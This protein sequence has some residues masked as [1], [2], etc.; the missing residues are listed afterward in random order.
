MVSAVSMTMSNLGKAWGYTKR[1]GEVI[2]ELI[3][4]SAS[5]TVGEALRTTKGSLFTKAQK[6]WQALEKAGSGN[7]FQNF[8]RN[9]KSFYPCIRANVL[10][11]TSAAKLTGK[12]VFLEGT[13]GFFKGIGKK[14][15]FIG[16]LTMMLF[17][18]PNIVTA[19]KEKGIFQGA[20][21]VVKSTARL[22]GGGLGAA[23]GSAL[24]PIPF[25]GTMAGWIAGEWLAG[26]IVG[27]SYSEKK[28]E[29]QKETEQQQEQT[30]SP[31]QQQEQPTGYMNPFWLPEAQQAQ[32]TNPIAQPPQAY[33][34]SMQGNGMYNPYANQ[35]IPYSDDIMM[36]QMPFNKIA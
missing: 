18:L 25:V 32:A 14:M 23:I 17:E 26:K 36:Q 28:A 5:E 15:P 20:A 24:V 21:E 10:T 35:N 9:F 6:G 16:A 19:T 8:I 34:P 30:A 2:P 33:N 3:F 7:F 4:G 22:T 1:V 27:K 29:K 11:K 13:K 31:A 12:N